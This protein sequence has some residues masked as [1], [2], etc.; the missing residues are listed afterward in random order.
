MEARYKDGAAYRWLNKHVTGSRTLDDMEDTSDWLFTGNGEMTLSDSR[1]KHGKHSLRLHSATGEA[2]TG[3]EGDWIDLQA[4]RKFSGED[5]TA[6]NR[7]SLWVY[8]DVKGAPAPAISCTLILHNDGT[9]KLP[10]RYNEG[11]NESIPLKNHEWNHVV[12]EIAP[13][14]RER[15]TAVDFAY[16]LPKKYPDPGDQTILYIDQLELQKVDADHVEG[17]DVAPGKIAF[18]G[19]GYPLIGTKTAM[20]SDLSAAM[21]SVIEEKSHRVVLTKAVK[22]ISAP[23]GAYE[24][25][26]FS[27]IHLPGT[28]F[29]RAGNQITRSFQIADN[30]WRGSIQKAINFLYGERCGT[31]I[32]GIHGSVIK[33]VIRSMPE[34]ELS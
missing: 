14:D 22:K 18:S 5:W 7:L 20:A 2:T 27:E 6:Y 26:D 11:R 9:H 12:W 32:P 25:L 1:F 29:I 31:V 17:W 10:D 8:P 34:S 30:P 4:T 16:S 23:L 19:S 3:G 33:I 15:V 24:L 21:F 13:L 28:Y